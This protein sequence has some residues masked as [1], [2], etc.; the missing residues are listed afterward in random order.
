M[1]IQSR[2]STSKVSPLIPKV[3]VPSIGKA[4]LPTGDLSWTPASTRSRYHLLSLRENTF[5]QS[6]HH[7][8]F[9]YCY[10]ALPIATFLGFYVGRVNE[11]HDNNCDVGC[12]AHASI[13]LKSK[14]SFMQHPTHLSVQAFVHTP[15][16]LALPRNPNSVLA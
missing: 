14:C 9:V 10:A 12:L 11:R 8:R 4:A 5:S 15:S 1:D 16:L 7:G 13:P 2:W 3:T 6:T